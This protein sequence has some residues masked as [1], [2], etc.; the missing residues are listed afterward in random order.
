M[1]E[2]NTLNISD[3]INIIAA[4]ELAI[5]KKKSPEL[6][7]IRRKLL[8]VSSLEERDYNPPVSDCLT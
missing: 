3:I 6:L 5:G 8:C 7:E 2:I 4:I 1:V